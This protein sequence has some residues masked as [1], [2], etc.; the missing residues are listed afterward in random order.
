[1]LSALIAWAVVGALF[2][3]VATYR[4]ERGRQVKA[5]PLPTPLPQ[6]LLLRPV[7]APTAQELS[8]LSAPVG[9][10]G[11]LRHVVLS[12]F[13]PRLEPSAAVE[14]L[15]SDPVSLNRK[16]G[17]LVYA[18]SALPHGGDTVVVAV[19][20]D[21]Q[22][23]AALVEG[24]VA[25]LAAGA[26]LASAA[27]RPAVHGSLGGLMLR[28]LL[29][30]SHHSFA[31][32]DVMTAGAKA[33]CGKAMAFSAPACARL[34]Q[35]SDCIG[36]DLELSVRLRER[37]LTVTS[38][39]APAQVPQPQGVA[40][41]ALVERITRWMQV[42]RFHRGA[43]FPSVPLLFTPVPL[44]LPLVV[45]AG[46]AQ[47]WAAFAVLV[48]T[49]IGL[50]SHQDGRFGLRLEWLLAEALLLWCWV[51]SWHAGTTVTWRGRTFELL[52]GGKM[53]E[54]WEAPDGVSP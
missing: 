33:I 7:D 51:V 6:V 53:R 27:P 32:L 40:V 28:G 29:V 17:H 50:A 9:Y 5:K 16:V 21:V 45:A 15:P 42:L 11:P 18:L 41:K 25:Q 49:R 26:H 2:T 14:W 48:A 8:N 22:V 38:S 19:D 12:P 44:L 10:R 47:L 20:A 23:D 13:R 24:L 30:Q 4:L 36:E 43:L 39:A 3:L 31:V 52:H 1:M 37:G 46:D 35:L 34:P 54:R